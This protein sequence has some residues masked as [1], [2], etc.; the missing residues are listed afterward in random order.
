MISRF[1]FGLSLL[2][3]FN[4]AVT[5]CTLGQSTNTLSRPTVISEKVMAA[6]LLDFPIPSLSKPPLANRCSNALAMLKVIVDKDGKVSEVKFVSGFQELEKPAVGAVKN[7][8]YKP[9]EVDGQPVAVET[10]VS[11]FFLGDGES[12]PMYMP[13]G[14]GSTKGGNILP[15]PPGCNPGPVIKRTPS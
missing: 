13:D 1:T 3:L 12:F 10:Q 9:Y 6:R 5:S 2:L 14:K 8:S 4:L 7:W 11:L 15:L